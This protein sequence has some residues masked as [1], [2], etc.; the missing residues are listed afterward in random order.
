MEVAP[1]AF[2]FPGHCS[3]TRLSHNERRLQVEFKK[4]RLHI[5]RVLA[6][7]VKAFVCVNRDVANSIGC[8]MINSILLFRGADPVPKDTSG[9]RPADFSGSI[10]EGAWGAK[11][12]F[13]AAVLSFP[14]EKKVFWWGLTHTLVRE[15]P[16]LSDHRRARNVVPGK[17]A[18]KRLKQTSDAAMAPSRQDGFNRGHDVIKQPTPA[19]FQS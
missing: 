5:W 4:Y 8:Q 2:L 7:P 19:P 11:S 16:P 3:G 1:P 15:L 18:M 10:F 14:E 12:D 6:Q 9:A 17:F 13:H